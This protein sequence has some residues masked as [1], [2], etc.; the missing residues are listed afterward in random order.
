M[1][2]FSKGDSVAQIVAPIAGE[3]LG[4]QV[5][6]ESG[7][8]LVLVGWTD[9]DGDHSRYFKESEINKTV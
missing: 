3:V 4:F 7:D 6:Q 5:D 1:A 2:K 8:L 9:A